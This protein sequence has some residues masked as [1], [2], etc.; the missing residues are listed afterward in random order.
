M[1]IVALLAV[2]LTLGETPVETHDRVEVKLCADAH[3]VPVPGSHGQFI[4][5]SSAG[6]MTLGCAHGRYH[7]K[8]IKDNSPL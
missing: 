1:R 2:L 8:W 6:V 4:I 3:D 5:V 7:P